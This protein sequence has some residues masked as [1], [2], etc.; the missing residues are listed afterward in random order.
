MLKLKVGSK[1]WRLR[2]RE[3]IDFFWNI[4]TNFKGTTRK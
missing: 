2:D 3:S 1:G 4:I